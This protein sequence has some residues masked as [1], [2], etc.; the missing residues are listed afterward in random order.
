MKTIRFGAAALV[1]MM[2]ASAG[3]QDKPAPAAQDKTAPA[4]QDKPAALRPHRECRS[5]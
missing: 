2:T 1:L 3:A 5:R 4:A